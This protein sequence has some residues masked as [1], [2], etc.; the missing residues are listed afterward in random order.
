MIRFIITNNLFIITDPLDS[1]I[2]IS[3][4]LSFMMKEFNHKDSFYSFINQSIS[5]INYY[6]QVIVFI[7]SL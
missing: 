4:A 1:F 7:G 3:W 2:V 5:I 6:H